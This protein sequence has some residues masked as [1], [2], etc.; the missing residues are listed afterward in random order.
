MNAT[1]II[2]FQPCL[3]SYNSRKYPVL[4]NPVIFPS[5]VF[6]SSNTFL[7]HTWLQTGNTFSTDIP[8]SHLQSPSAWRRSSSFCSLSSVLRSA[9][10]HRNELA[11]TC[12]I[13]IVYTHYV[14][15][16]DDSSDSIFLLLIKKKR[17]RHTCPCDTYANL[18]RLLANLSWLI[19][20]SAGDRR[21]KELRYEAW[22]LS[23]SGPEE[24]CV[25]TAGPNAGSIALLSFGLCLG[26]VLVSFENK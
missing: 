19:R 21:T 24:D 12:I 11:F 9:S 10:F 16:R 18:T 4:V 7:T 13:L 6:E 2:L 15:L 22:T 20:K 23:L 17:L 25:S 8:A 3:L 1:V 5:L 26:T 14:A